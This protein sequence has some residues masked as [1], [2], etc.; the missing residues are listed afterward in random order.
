[1][2]HE[3]GVSARLRQDFARSGTL[4]NRAD[5]NFRRIMDEEPVFAFSKHFNS[6]R[7]SNSSSS[8]ESVTFTIAHVQDPVVQFAS[9]RGLTLMR[10]LWESYF[11]DVESLLKFHYQDFKDASTL[12]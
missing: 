12:A 2:K 3:A 1:V 7:T 5:K 9:A 10:P 4:K 8:T 11:H 6:N